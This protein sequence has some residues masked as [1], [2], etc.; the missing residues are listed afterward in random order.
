MMGGGGGGGIPVNAIADALMAK[1]YGGNSKTIDIGQAQAWMAL[2]EE[3]QKALAAAYFSGYNI[4][5]TDKGTTNYMMENVFG[6][7]YGYGVVDTMTGAAPV[8][9]APTSG[10]GRKGNT[11]SGSKEYNSERTNKWV[12]G[13]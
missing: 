13:K 9:T 12:F 2:P 10:A 6:P 11:N 1:G 3:Q 7:R 8:V 5:G 4:G